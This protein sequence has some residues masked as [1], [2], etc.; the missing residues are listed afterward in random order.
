MVTIKKKYRADIFRGNPDGSDDFKHFFTASSDLDAKRKMKKKY[1]NTV[2]S[3]YR[4][5]SHHSIWDW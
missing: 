4:K 3:V 2:V 1:K 5:H